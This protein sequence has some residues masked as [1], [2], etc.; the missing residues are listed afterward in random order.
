MTLI[1]LGKSIRNGRDAL[2]LTQVSFA[3]S[4]GIARRTLT[5]IEAGDPAVRIGTF[6]RAAQ[7]LGLRLTISASLHQRPTLDELA[8]IYDDNDE[9]S[10]RR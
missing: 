5:R 10:T 2:G 7:A 4:S 9:S 3:R 8:S 6:E 1:H